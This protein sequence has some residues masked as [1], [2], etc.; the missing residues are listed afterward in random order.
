MSLKHADEEAIFN[1]A[2]KIESASERAAYLKNACAG[3]TDLLMRVQALLKVHDQDQNFLESPILAPDSC[4]TPDSTP[5]SEGPGTV[6]GPYK[7]LEQIG[8]GGMGVVYMAEQTEPVERRVALKIIKLGMDTRQVIARFE[9]ERQALAMMDHPHIAKVLDAGTSQSGRPYFVMELVKGVP[10]TEYCDARHLTTRQRLELFLPVCRAVQHAHQK[11]IIHR[12]LKPSNVMVALYDDRP[13]PKIIDF[14]VAKATSQKLTEKTMFTQ[15]G[16]I[17]GTLEYMSPEQATLNQLDIDTRSDI[18]SLGVLLYELL[19]GTTPFEKQRLRSS[20]F[21]EMLRIIREEEPLKPSTRLTQLQPSPEVKIVNHKSKIENDLDWIVMKALEKDRTRRY[22]T[23]NALAVDIAHYLSDEP[24]VACPPSAAYKFRKFARRNMVVLTTAAIVITALLLG[25]AVSTWQAI[26]ASKAEAVA[27]KERNAAVEA[28]GK[29]ETARREADDQRQQAQAYA[30]ENSERL[31]RSYV[32]HGVRLMDDGDLM[33]SLVWFAE[34]LKLDEGNTD[35]EYVHRVRIARVL[36][37]CPKLVQLWAHDGPVYYA[38]FSPACDRV[39][40]ASDDRTARVYDALSGALLATLKHDTAVLYAKF[41]H[42][43]QRL[44]TVSGTAARVWN[45]TTGQAVTPPMEHK[46]NVNHVALSPDG[47]RVATASRDGTARVWNAATGDPVTPALE[48]STSVNSVYFSPDGQRLLSAGVTAVPDGIRG[49]VRVWDATNGQPIGNALAGPSSNALFSP[50]GR[51]VVAVTANEGAQ[52]CDI[53]T[54]QTLFSSMKDSAPVNYAV[55]SPDGRRVLTTAANAAKVWDLSTGQAVTPPLQ[56]SGTVRRASFSHDGRCVLTASDDGTVRVWDSASGQP[57]SPTLRHAGRV[58]QAEFSRDAERILTAT[59]DGVVRIWDV[60]SEEPSDAPL[61]IG[62]QV[63]SAAF[64]PDGCSIATGENEFAVLWSANRRTAGQ[65]LTCHPDK[66]IGVVIGLA[67]SPD[68]R[69]L[70]IACT[71][72]SIRVWDISNGLLLSKLDHT[73]TIQVGPGVFAAGRQRLHAEF[74]PD[75]S[76]VLTSGGLASAEDNA[77][78]V[79]DPTTGKQIQ[80]LHHGATVT[81]AT[82]SED[83]R[84]ILTSSHDKTAQ[85]WDASTGKSLLTLSHEREVVWAA[86]SPD[87]RR[88]VTGCINGNAWIWDVSTGRRLASALKHS[89]LVLDAAFSPDGRLVATG[90]NDSTGRIWETSS[91]K[92]LT[93]PLR[94]NEGV[95]T[96]SFSPNGLFVMTGSYDDTARVWDART[97]Q[98]VAPPLRHLWAVSDCSF[99]PDNQR[100][101][102]ACWDGTARLWPWAPAHRPIQDL[103]LLASVLSTQQVDEVAGLVSLE[104]AALADAWEVL[105]KRYPSDFERSSSAIPPWHRVQ[106]Q[107]A[108]RAV[109]YREML[110]HLDVLV[111]ANPSCLSHRLVRANLRAELGLWPEA[112]E[113]YRE[114]VACG[115]DWSNVHS[116]FALCSLAAGD[117]DRYRKTCVALLEKFG[118]HGDENTVAWTCALAP[119]SVDD[120]SGVVRLAERAVTA[121]PKAWAWIEL[122]SLGMALCRAGRF[123]EAIETLNRSIEAQRAHEAKTNAS[124]TRPAEGVPSQWLVL[125]M[126]HHRLGHVAQAR[127]W[128]DKADEWIDQK[129]ESV[130]YYG[131]E[132]EWPER[133]ERQFLRREAEALIGPEKR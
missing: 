94:H 30:E 91:G 54:G 88:A 33:G 113:D 128:L 109:D 36:K 2:R 19:T 63:W 23:A 73:S 61:G 76:R 21:E 83:G 8:E 107:Q 12:D 40:T 78:K 126:C 111:S 27:T 87:G 10:L 16:Q 11:G 43:G 59:G 80:R 34:A 6:I 85:I 69:R 106:A 24:V 42:D 129:R 46:G 38:E 64:S 39:V 3:H 127:S 65:G 45:W 93:P 86:Y 97:G 15:Y 50:D 114:A 112:A 31:M 95:H 60:A 67:F 62:L 20:A 52:V 132:V 5:L 96:V 110:S 92:L 101:L 17:V 68:A 7:L 99:S 66:V 25:T 98:P 102:T 84:Q 131:A 18:Y 49:E 51:R 115:A 1:E 56:H 53:E 37:E 35:R 124:G 104:A 57:L 122:K 72:G 32:D 58:T 74:S 103:L 133:L 100:V 28:Q 48:H 26:R 79:W 89:L 70:A 4:T 108:W 71:D 82:F 118:A 14:G 77:A 41:A 119:D 120:W 123:E 22:E 75:G 47:N 29:A 121:N 44:I 90:S 105:S 116:K 117:M 81:N 125:A 130:G 13:V 55:F 9:A